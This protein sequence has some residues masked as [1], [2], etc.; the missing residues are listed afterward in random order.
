MTTGAVNGVTAVRV[1][2]T[3]S[4]SE[5]PVV[6]RLPEQLPAP[7]MSVQV[8]AADASVLGN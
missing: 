3:T 7:A 6:A 1:R 4:T 5:V 8:R 2:R